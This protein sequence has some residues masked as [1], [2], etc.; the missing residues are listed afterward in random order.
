MSSKN[1]LFGD[2]SSEADTDDLIAA[3][4][5]QP[6]ATKKNKGGNKKT[7]SSPKKAQPDADNDSGDDEDFGSPDKQSE[8]GGL[9]DS[10][11]EDEDDD[12]APKS[13]K[14][15][16]AVKKKTKKLSSSS[17]TAT[18]QQAKKKKAPPTKKKDGR[19]MKQKM[20]ELAKK[21]RQ[22]ANGGVDAQE[23][24]SEQPRRKRSKKKQGEGGEEGDKKGYESGD[25][26]DSTTFARTKEDDDF[27]DADDEDPEALKELYAEQHF[28]DER[29]DGYDSE[30]EER[31]KKAAAGG[32][33]NSSSG[34]GGVDKISLSDD[35][36]GPSAS[37]ALKDAVR[38]MQRKKKEV[39]KLPQ[40]EQEATDF[41]R[42]MDA[43]ADADDESIA[44][45][46]PALKKLGMLSEVM[47]ML[48]QKDLQRVLLDLDLLMVC[49]RW[50]QP[51]P[52]NGKT[53][54]NLTVRR[55]IIESLGGMTGENGINS[56]DLK[57]SGFGKVVMALFKHKSETPDMKKMLKAMIEQWSRPIFQKSG[58]LRDLERAQMVRGMNEMGSLVGIARQQAQQ[59]QQ[60]SGQKRAKARGGRGGRAANEDDLAQI[61]NTGSKNSTDIGNNRVRVPYS[62]GFQFSVRPADRTGDVSDKR[63]LVSAK[64]ARGG[65]G[66]MGREGEDRKD[67]LQKRMLN[68]ARP[69]NK[70]SQRSANIS[71]EGRVVK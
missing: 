9:F 19:T 58:N 50:V 62:K 45:K 39:K 22:A 44:A 29:P 48:A 66:G 7:A 34:G 46:K 59:Q 12:D 27:I 1:D 61:I 41:L 67:S 4:K 30:E 56:S 53:L 14:K 16:G 8:G 33:N 55:R 64:A 43:A 28:D 47:E 5:S 21:K 25:S 2:S 52:P 60:S 49:K 68:K 70:Q 3:A 10:S 51:L 65:G 38:R 71:I 42:K 57:R 24:E 36:D 35:E 54:G 17:S 37:A 11:S 13:K 63:N 26:Y 32:R 15:K 20:E 31:K 23:E 40:L 18:K 6:I 69:V